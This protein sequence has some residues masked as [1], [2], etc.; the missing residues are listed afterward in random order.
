MGI[1]GILNLSCDDSLRT[2]FDTIF[3]SQFNNMN[4]VVDQKEDL[5]CY[6]RLIC[7]NSGTRILGICCVDLCCRCYRTL[8]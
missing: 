2:D 8:D 5:D 6:A 7:E 4:G 3:K 1:H